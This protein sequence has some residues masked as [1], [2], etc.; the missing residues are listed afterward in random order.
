MSQKRERKPDERIVITGMGLVSC[1]GSDLN[2]FYTALLEGKSGVR[3]IT[4]LPIESLPTRFAAYIEGFDPGPYIDKK[5]ARRIDPFIA[6]ALVAGKRALEHAGLNKDSLAGRDMTRCGVIIGSGIGGLHMMQNQIPMVDR[7]EFRQISPFFIPYALTN[8]ASGLIAIDCGFKG[9]NYSVSTACATSNYAII[10]AAAHI[11]SG[12]ADI[13]LCGGAEAPINAT[14]LAGFSALH[15]LSRRNDD[16]ARACCPWT[17]ERDGFVMG[18][19]AGVLCLERLDHALA[20]KAPIYAEYLGGGMS[21]DAHHMTEVMGCG[22]GLVQ[23]MQNALLDAHVEPEKVDYVNAHATSTPQGDM[24]EIR[25]LQRLLPHPEKVILNA[26]KPN[27][28]HS[29][30][31]AG[32]L[33][34]IVSVLALNKAQVHP[35][36]NTAQLDPEVRMHVPQKAMKAPIEIAM[37][38]SFGFGGHNASIVFKRF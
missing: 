18:E 36:L 31:A 19:G 32:A 2:A 22:T 16:P 25:A 35:T 26:T 4:H 28:G 29:L 3:T 27:V 37:S 1:F 20:R 10:S 12:A 23:C 21:C 13:M 8:M 30:G 15:A 6:Y 34:A 33:E 5:Q 24:I 17:R 14:G 11:R 38:N 9:P 7:S